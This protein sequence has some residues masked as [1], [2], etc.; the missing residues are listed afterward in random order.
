MLV[1]FDERNHCYTVNGDLA[2]ESVTEMLGRQGLA[3]DYSGVKEELLATAREKGKEIH[4]DLESVL[5]EQHYEPKTKQGKQFKTWAVDNI[6][7]G[8]GEQAV[9]FI[10]DSVLFAGTA[11]VVGL[12]KDGEFFVGDHKTTAT[13]H[14]EYVTWQTS[15]YD[16]FL[17][18]IGGNQR[19]NGKSFANYTG[20]KKF[21]CFQYDLGKGTMKVHELDKIP[22]EEIERL[23]D[24]EIKGEKYIRPTLV[25]TAKLKQQWEK[26]EQSLIALKE[27]LAVKEQQVKELRQKICAEMERQNIKSFE[28]EN[29]KVTYVYPTDILTVDSTT[30]KRQFPQVWEKCQK[31]SHK[32]SF[33][34][35]TVKGE[36]DDNV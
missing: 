10:R 20:A 30:L 24:C 32:K 29:L 25:V 5:N 1:Q 31:V 17:R 27:K 19:I 22:D 8:V 11:D 34:R 3:P 12:T 13:F 7:C 35:V 26:A 21:Y 36:N 2:S 4:S 33:I 28:S 15:L 14:R 6:D 9:G 16:Y 18:H 23:L